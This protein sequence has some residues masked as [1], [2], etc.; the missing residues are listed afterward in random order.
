MQSDT[1]P[2]TSDI[3]E[4][5]EIQN[6]VDTENQNPENISPD[7]ESV[8]GKKS[9]K[10]KEKVPRKVVVRHALWFFC[11]ILWGATLMFIGGV[12]YLR[13]NLIQ[14]I[15]LEGDFNSVAG[16]IGPVAQRYGWQIS[17]TQCGLPRQINGQPMEVYRLCKAPYAYELLE[18]ES[19]RKISSMLPCAISIYKK[20]DGVTYISKVN[21]PLVTQLL[22]GKS[23][24]IF[25]KK[26]VPEQE[27][28]MS[29]FATRDEKKK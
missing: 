4:E 16:S 3:S 26:I 18:T 25:N 8:S 20:S 12:L 14:E 23:V 29:H 17:Y 19:E 21:M 5:P 22:G 28:I 7:S 11:G 10:Q 24:E 2:K 27:A 9:K 6:T 1:S 13:H 15:P